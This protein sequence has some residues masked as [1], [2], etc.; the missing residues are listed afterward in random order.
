MYS[1]CQN[2]SFNAIM[3]FRRTLNSLPLWRAAS[4]RQLHPLGTYT[5]LGDAFPS[6]KLCLAG[7]PGVTFMEVFEPCYK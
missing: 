2:P 7:T 4:W 3:A 5:C 6:A 1:H